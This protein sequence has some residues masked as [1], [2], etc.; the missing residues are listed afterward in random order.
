MQGQIATARASAAS[1]GRGSVG[2]A[3][4]HLDHPLD[5]L[6]VGAAVA[7][8]RDL[9][10]VRAVLE[11]GQAV[12]GRGEQDHAA[13][14]AHRERR[15][16][17]LLKNSRSTPIGSGLWVRSARRTAVDLEQARAG[18]WPGVGSVSRQP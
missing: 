3:Q 11:D 4:D 12:L 5:L 1:S 7:G 14:L 8:D 2:H 13:R 16:H 17:V 15:L 18:S 9:D 10:L 6:L